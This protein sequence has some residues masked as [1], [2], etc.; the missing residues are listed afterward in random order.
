MSKA[1]TSAGG[2]IGCLGFFIAL[3]LIIGMWSWSQGA[4]PREAASAAMVL[5][6]KITGG[7]CCFGTAL[8]VGVA[9]LA[10]SSR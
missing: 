2:G 4:D 10:G 6:A 7:L 3:A 1:S 8:V 5:S 9:A